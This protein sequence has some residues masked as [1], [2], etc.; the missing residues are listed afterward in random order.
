VWTN[1]ALSRGQK[2]TMFRNLHL[3]HHNEH[4]QQMVK[5]SRM[6]GFDQKFEAKHRLHTSD[7]ILDSR[8]AS[9]ALVGGQKI[10]QSAFKTTDQIMHD[11][12]AARPFV[13]FNKFDTAAFVDYGR[14]KYD[15]NEDFR[16]EQGMLTNKDAAKKQ[17]M[18]GQVPEKKN[19]KRRMVKRAVSTAG[20]G[21]VNYGIR[22]LR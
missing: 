15:K 22:A 21:V 6:Q 17:E 5:R 8:S 18:L 1:P 4:S 3:A 19:K 7:T 20:R 12:M 13:A 11:R 10:P 9:Q 16:N 14:P 2:E